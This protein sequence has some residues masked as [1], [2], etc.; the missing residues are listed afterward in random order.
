MLGKRLKF[1]FVF[2]FSDQLEVLKSINL[3]HIICA[4]SSVDNLQKNIFTKVDDG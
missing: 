3:D 4:T 1:I 2:N